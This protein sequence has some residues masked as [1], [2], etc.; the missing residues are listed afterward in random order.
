MKDGILI[1]GR[2]ACHFNC[3]PYRSTIAT[4]IGGMLMRLY[5]QGALAIA[6]TITRSSMLSA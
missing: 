2:A 5:K 4:G 3:A 1:L 6:I